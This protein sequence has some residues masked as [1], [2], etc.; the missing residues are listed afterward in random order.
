MYRHSCRESEYLVRLPT[1]K[2]PSKNYSI[3]RH[4]QRL[5]KAMRHLAGFAGEEQKLQMIGA[6]DLTQ[7]HNQTPRKGFH[8]LW[9]Q[10]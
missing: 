1:G 4:V 6:S 8:R 2:W 3:S 5:C 10:K 9:S 7:A